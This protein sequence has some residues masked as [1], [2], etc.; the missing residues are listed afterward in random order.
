MPAEDGF[1]RFYGNS[2]AVRTLIDMIARDRIPQTL[3]LDGPEGVGK[4]TLARRF[5]ACLLYTSLI[6]YTD[7][8][9]ELAVTEEPPVAAG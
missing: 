9:Q 7:P 2:E 8:S 3:L 4:A 5:A 1:P 6:K